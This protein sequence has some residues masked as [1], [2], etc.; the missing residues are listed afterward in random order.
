LGTNWITVS[1]SAGTNQTTV[2]IGQTNGSVFFRLK[3][4]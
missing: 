3:Y 4:P 2:P 1:D